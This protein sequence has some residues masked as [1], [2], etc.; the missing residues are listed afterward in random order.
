VL[1]NYRPE[2]QHGWGS[3]TYYR[4]LRIDPLPP[5]SAEEMLAALLGPDSALGPLK[6]LLIERTEEPS[7]SRACEPCRDEAS[8][9]SGGVPAA[10]APERADPGNGS[11]HSGCRSIASLRRTSGFFKRP[12]LSADV[13]FTLLQAIADESEEAMRQGLGRLQA[14]EFLYEARLFPDLEYTFKHALT[15]EV[16]YGSLLQERRRALHGRM[17]EAIEARYGDRLSEQA[18]RL[19]HHAFRGGSGDGHPLRP[20]G[21]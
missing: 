21:R 11:G 7:S 3:K 20:P 5:E 9:A 18:D 19:A 8:P 15:H 1:V 14:A 10:K 2:Y 17:V 16:A 13:P 4:Q 6:R 12:P